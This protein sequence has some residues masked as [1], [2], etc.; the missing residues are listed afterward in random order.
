[1]ANGNVKGKRFDQLYRPD[2]ADYEQRFRLTCPAFSLEG[3]GVD[4]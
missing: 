1:M 4:Y 3:A 2:Y